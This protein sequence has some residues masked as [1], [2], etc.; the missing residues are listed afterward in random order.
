METKARVEIRVTK[1]ELTRD[2]NL[3]A[4]MDCFYNINFGTSRFKS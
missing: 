3:F 1:A 2:V 4:T